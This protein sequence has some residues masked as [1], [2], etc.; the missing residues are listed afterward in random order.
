MVSAWLAAQPVCE[1]LGKEDAE[2]ARK[3][4]WQLNVLASDGCWTVIGVRDAL[5]R[6]RK[7]AWYTRARRERRR[8]PQPAN[9]ISGPRSTGL[10]EQMMRRR[11]L[12]IC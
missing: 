11:P 6:E 2:R 8:L 1:K 9:D 3:R 10:T 4:I 5:Q 7:P 12:G